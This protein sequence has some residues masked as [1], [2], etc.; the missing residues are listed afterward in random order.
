MSLYCTLLGRIGS[1]N[2]ERACSAALVCFPFHFHKRHFST[3]LQLIM[4]SL[5][6]KMFFLTVKCRIIALI[7][8]K[9]K[10]IH[11]IYADFLFKKVFFDIILLL[12]KVNNVS[13]QKRRK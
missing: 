12:W 5:V 4:E 11:K 9:N 2:P 8:Q 10:T 1:E 3:K 7:A 6:K 13:L